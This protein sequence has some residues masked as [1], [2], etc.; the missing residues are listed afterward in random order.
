MHGNGYLTQ[1]NNKICTKDLERVFGESISLIIDRD[2][3]TVICLGDNDIVSK[4][5]DYLLS[6]NL[7]V[8]STNLIFLELDVMRNGLSVDDIV[9]LVNYMRNTIGK[10]SMEEILTLLD[11]KD[12]DKIKKKV[13]YLQ[14]YEF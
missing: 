10:E 13:I 9:T 3:A 8:F 11:S 14:Q 1:V 5:Y 2:T 6:T 7:Y 4:K 12:T